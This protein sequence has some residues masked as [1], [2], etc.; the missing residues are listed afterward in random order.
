MNNKDQILP[1]EIKSILSKYYNG[2]TTIE[3]ERLL[4][5]YFVQNQIPDSNLSDKAL[6]SFVNDEEL[7]IFPE[8]EIWSKILVTEK[9]KRNQRKTIQILSSVAAS[10]LIVFSFSIWYSYPTKHV[11]T[12]TDTYSNPHEAYKA[13]QKY[14]GLVSTKLAYAYTEIRPIGKLAIPVEAMQSFS[15]IDKNVKRLQQFRILEGSA[16]EL[17]RFSIISDIVIVDKN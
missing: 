13:V 8:N 5:K 16:H 2:R 7:P 14:L 10:I 17:K 6:L 4:K 12:L 1:E 9:K 3:E 11:E 15:A